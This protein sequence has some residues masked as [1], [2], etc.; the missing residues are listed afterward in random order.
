LDGHQLAAGV[1]DLGLG[2]GSCHVGG[3][4]GSRCGVVCN[5]ARLRPARSA[6]PSARG[7]SRIIAN[8]WPH[9]WPIVATLHSPV[10]RWGLW[11]SVG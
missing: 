7:C 2:G 11:G 3:V 6:R 8:S 5:W 4:H 1:D 9:R 10:R